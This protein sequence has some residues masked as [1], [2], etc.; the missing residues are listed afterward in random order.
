MKL[1]DLSA[2]ITLAIFMC[3]FCDSRYTPP[4]VESVAQSNSDEIKVAPDPVE[5]FVFCFAPDK[6]QSPDKTRLS[7]I[8]SAN[9]Y[10]ECME[11]V[12]RALHRLS[13]L[14]LQVSDEDYFNRF[15]FDRGES[16][17][18]MNGSALRLSHYFPHKLTG[19][20]TSSPD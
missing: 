15:Y 6:F 11:K 12:L 5:N 13:A 19:T 3:I 4:G 7:P 9:E 10:F 18:V 14:S 2:C 20:H 16:N 8:P 1:A 17:A